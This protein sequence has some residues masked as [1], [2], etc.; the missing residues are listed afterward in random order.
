MG[1]NENKSHSRNFEC[2]IQRLC[3]LF[4]QPLFALRREP[5]PPDYCCNAQA[6]GTY[7][8]MICGARA[9]ASSFSS[10]ILAQT[11]AAISL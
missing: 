3:A 5:A 4:S 6:L 11:L 9:P 8:M 2:K 1:L 7:S 10:P